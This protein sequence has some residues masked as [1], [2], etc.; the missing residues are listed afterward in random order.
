MGIDFGWARAAMNDEIRQG[1]Y[2]DVFET[3]RRNPT[4]NL[5]FTYT[6]IT[7]ISDAPSFAEEIVEK[8]NKNSLVSKAEF[9]LL[10]E[11]VLQIISI[12]ATGDDDS[13]LV[14]FDVE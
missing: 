3:I 6:W 8:V 12:R 9:L 14:D 5:R 2:A 10:R 4:S 1:E 11:Y 7:L 13:V